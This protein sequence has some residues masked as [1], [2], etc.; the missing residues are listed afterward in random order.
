MGGANRFSS[1]PSFQRMS[2][3]KWE[4]PVVNKIHVRG[5]VGLVPP[6]QDLQIWNPVIIIV[7]SGVGGEGDFLRNAAAGF[8]GRPAGRARGP[9]D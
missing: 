1:S 2:S 6:N 3:A 7:W 5:P 4:E 8:D 9:A